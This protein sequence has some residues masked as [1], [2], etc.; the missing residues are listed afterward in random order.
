MTHRKAD[1]RQAVRHDR[2][3][4]VRRL[5]HEEGRPLIEADCSLMALAVMARPDAVPDALRYLVSLGLDVNEPD[6]WGQPPL[7]RACECGY[8][9]TM[10]FLLESGADARY[11][12]GVG[13]TYPMLAAWEKQT[14]GET[15]EDRLGFPTP[16]MSHRYP[17]IIRTLFAGGS[18]LNARNRFGD[19]VVDYAL[20]GGNRELAADLL[21][22]QGCPDHLEDR[23]C[24]MRTVDFRWGRVVVARFLDGQHF[25][26]C[27][28]RPSEFTESNKFCGTIINVDEYNAWFE[29]KKAGVSYVEGIGGINLSSNALHAFRRHYA[30]AMSKA[31]ADFQSRLPS[32]DFFLVALNGAAVRTGTLESAFE[33]ELSHALF[34]FDAEYRRLAQRAWSVLSDG[35]R[36]EWSEFFEYCD[37]AQ[38]VHVDEFAAYV[39]DDVPPDI[40]FAETEETEAIRKYFRERTADASRILRAQ[41]YSNHKRP[42]MRNKDFRHSARA[43]GIIREC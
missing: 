18:D 32:G 23:F 15:T 33:H 12:N 19:D 24:R 1:L 26:D 31:E 36:A 35:E 3:D 34:H 38:A 2:V 10:Q 43:S 6:E 22:M 28:L 27:L 21:R 30:S 40:D 11:R 14:A 42:F 25:A 37:Y 20:M 8:I 29:A 16:V 41:P 13:A 39:V 4:L 5:I 17:E 7:G 9:P